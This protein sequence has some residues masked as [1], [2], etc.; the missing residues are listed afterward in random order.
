MKVFITIIFLLTTNLALAC[1]ASILEQDGKYF[2]AI[3]KVG[4]MPGEDEVSEKKFRRGL[5][6]VSFSDKS[7]EP[8]DKEI[9]ESRKSR[10]KII[11]DSTD[12]KV[13]ERMYKTRCLN[14]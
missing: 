3:K 14:E 2:L 9:K 10:I 1:N 5:Q 7:E 11:Y 6:E 4:D 12:R 8:N 13:I